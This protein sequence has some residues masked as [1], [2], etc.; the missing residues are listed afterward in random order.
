MAR[1]IRISL[2]LFVSAIVMIF[3]TN[4]RVSELATAKQAGLASSAVESQTR[5]IYLGYGMAITFGAISLV[6][7]IMAYS[8]MRRKDS[9]ND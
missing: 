5:M 9:S 6:F 7:L 4:Q 2:T 8:Q 1:L 3:L